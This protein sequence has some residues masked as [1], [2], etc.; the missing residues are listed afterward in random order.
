[1]VQLL[2]GLSQLP[3]KEALGLGGGAGFRG[4]G[5][6]AWHFP[7]PLARTVSAF[8]LGRTDFCG[9]AQAPRA[10]S[11]AARVCVSCS[12]HPKA[13]CARESQIQKLQAF[14][15][16]EETEMQS[17]VLKAA[18]D[19]Q[20]IE[21][22]EHIVWS[23]KLSFLDKLMCHLHSLNC[24]YVPGYEVRR[25]HSNRLRYED[26]FVE[27][28]VLPWARLARKRQ[29]RL[30]QGRRVPFS[31]RT[32][33]V[34]LALFRSTS[35]SRGVFLGAVSVHNGSCRAQ[36]VCPY[37]LRLVSIRHTPL[38]T[39]RMERLS[40]RVLFSSRRSTRITDA[41]RQRTVS[42]SIMKNC[43]RKRSQQAGKLRAARKG[44]N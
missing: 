42:T 39:L 21:G 34:S 22:E 6:S 14:F 5:I 30:V 29:A 18:R 31:L 3:D 11:T 8:A 1:M 12:A 19:T 33:R 24:K 4:T 36:R 7:P 17:E 13:I 37:L 32:E 15:M 38:P 9:W 43:A 25:R 23:A 16:D 41:N 26:D 2:R 20:Q 35:P 40:E 10:R 44:R 28:L 27:R